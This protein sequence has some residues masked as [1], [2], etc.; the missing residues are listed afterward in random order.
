MECRKEA[1]YP[2]KVAYKQ[3]GL[4]GCGS[5]TKFVDLQMVTGW[6]KMRQREGLSY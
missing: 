1:T 4:T 6:E 3:R 5:E 2:T